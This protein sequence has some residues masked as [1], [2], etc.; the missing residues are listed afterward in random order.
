MIR[1]VATVAVYVTDQDE[2]L[3]FWTEKVGFEL[4]TE[5][6]MGDAR[7]LEV[8][9]PGAASALVLYPKAMMRE[10]LQPGI[11]FEVD[12]IEGTC[13]RLTEAGVPFAK[14][15]REMPWGRFASFLDPEGTEFGLRE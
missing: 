9:P 12:D 8:A 4:R 14:P 15:L 7:W 11:V 10:P 6:S 1:H 3:R 13:A 2:A 5:R